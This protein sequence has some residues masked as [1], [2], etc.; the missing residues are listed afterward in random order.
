M[1]LLILSDIHGNKKDAEK[2]LK[3]EKYDIAITAGDYELYDDWVEANFDYAVKGNNDLSSK[4]PVEKYFTLGN[5]KIYLQHGDK[6]GPYHTLMDEE[7]LFIACRHID[8]KIII[9]GHSHY[10]VYL[11]DDENNKY[12]INPGSIAFPRF[13]SEK[14]YCIV[15]LDEKVGHVKNVKFKKVK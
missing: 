12:F 11:Y 10:P 9:F 1:K 15:D 8:A 3:E 7:D 2:I 14:S 13:G 4:M 5:T 6:I